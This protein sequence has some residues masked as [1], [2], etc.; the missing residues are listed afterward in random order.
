LS[1][2]HKCFRGKRS[3]CRL[4]QAVARMKWLRR[5]VWQMAELRYSVTFLS[6]ASKQS[7]FFFLHWKHPQTRN[8]LRFQTP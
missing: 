1:E 3:A 2:F 6:P 5:T 4:L 7:L 8:I